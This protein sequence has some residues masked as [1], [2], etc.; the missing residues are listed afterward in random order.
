MIFIPKSEAFTCKHEFVH[1]VSLPPTQNNE[2]LS[3]VEL[4]LLFKWISL[5]SGFR[6]GGKVAANKETSCSFLASFAL[7]KPVARENKSWSSGTSTKHELTSWAS[8]SVSCFFFWE[9]FFYDVTGAFCWHS[10][11]SFDFVYAFKFDPTW[12]KPQ[13]IPTFSCITS[14]HNWFIRCDGEE[15]EKLCNNKIKD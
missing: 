13:T 15:E 11:K 4:P 12:R 9:W 6:M 5:I 14:F 2:Q 7:M 3:V 1:S 8:V 10:F